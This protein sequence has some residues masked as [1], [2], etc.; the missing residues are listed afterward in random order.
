MW[1]SSILFVAIQRRYI[2]VLI[3][4]ENP[5]SLAYLYEHLSFETRRCNA[6][7]YQLV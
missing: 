7:T 4:K 3:F 2:T 5:L 6:E 1:V